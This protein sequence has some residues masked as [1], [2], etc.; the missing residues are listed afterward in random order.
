N[1]P[2]GIEY[3][4][5]GCKQAKQRQPGKCD[6]TL[7]EHF[8]GAAIEPMATSRVQAHNAPNT[9]A[10]ASGLLSCRMKRR[11]GISSTAEGHAM[12]LPSS[13]ANSADLE[14]DARLVNAR[15]DGISP[16]DI[17]I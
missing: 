9:P 8:F 2:D 6:A 13:P 3:R 1:V 11:R 14:R 5:A 15:H 12:N 16:G 7:V 17:A 4:A 10:C